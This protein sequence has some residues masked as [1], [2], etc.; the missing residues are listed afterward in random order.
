M[1]MN[2]ATLIVTTASNA[3]VQIPTLPVAKLPGLDI[4][5]ENAANQWAEKLFSQA[6]P[7]SRDVARFAAGLVS[8]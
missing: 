8:L 4:A 2:N 3:A 6:R 5:V 7:A 1:G